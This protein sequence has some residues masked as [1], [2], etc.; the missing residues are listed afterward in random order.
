MLACELYYYI[1]LES[2]PFLAAREKVVIGHFSTV[3]ATVQSERS[4][5]TLQVK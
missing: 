5:E 1:Y 3:C 4:C 2:S